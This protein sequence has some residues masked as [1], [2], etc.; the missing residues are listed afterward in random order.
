MGFSGLLQLTVQSMMEIESDKSEGWGEWD[1]EIDDRRVKYFVRFIVGGYKFTKS[2]WRGGDVAEVLYDYEKF[3]VVKKRKR[4]V[5]N[6]KIN[7][8]GGYVLK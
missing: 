1:D 2:M 4:E 7:V 5:G 3:K 6:S 8:E